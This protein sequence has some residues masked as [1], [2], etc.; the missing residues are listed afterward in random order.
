[1]KKKVALTAAAVAL[2]GTLAVGGTLAWFTDTE[3]ATNTITT[4]HVDHTIYEASGS[5]AFK[6]LPGDGTGITFTEKYVPNA[7]IPKKVKIKNED[8][9]NTAFIRVKVVY[10]HDTLSDEN[11]H[12]DRVNWE[13]NGD[14]WYYKTPVAGGD[15][16]SELFDQVT[17]PNWGNEMADRTGDKALKIE[18]IT[19]SIQADNLPDVNED[20]VVNYLD[21]ARL[22]NEA[23]EKNAS[24]L[25]KL[26]YDV[27]EK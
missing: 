18:L 1:M 3:T 16:T 17:L 24:D 10:N 27:D 21:A 8:D 9:S 6:E 15:Y 20:G 23:Y 12:F 26:N 19:D 7:V 4:G 13:K 11:V 5:E 14:Y 22:L 2:V 25:E